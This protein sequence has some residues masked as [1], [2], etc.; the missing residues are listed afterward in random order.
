MNSYRLAVA[1]PVA[2]SMLFLAIMVFGIYAFLRLPVDL[3]PNIDVP[4]LSVITVYPGAGALEVEQNVTD[5]LEGVLGTVPNLKKMTSN[6]LDD[7]SVV[8]LEFDW[9]VDMSEAAND[10]RDRLGRASRLLPDG[11][12]DPF[13]QK[14][15]AG[16]IPVIIY[17]ATATESYANLE[18]I[19]NDNLVGPLNRIAGVGD[20]TITGA[21]ARQIH[22]TLD[23]ARLEAYNLDIQRVSQ[24]LQAENLSTPAGRIDLGDA[25]YNLRVN[26]EFRDLDDIAN[27]IVAN[28]QGRTVRLHQVGTVR[29]GF[30]DDV[31]VS[32]VNGRQGLTFAVM[33][34]SDANTVEVARAV[35]ARMPALLPSLPPDVEVEIIIDTSDFIVGSIENLSS[36]LFYA[37]LFVVLV[38]LVFLRQWRATIVV[39][40]TIPVSL[41]VAFIYLSLTGSTLNII[42]LSSLSIALGMVVDDAIVVLENIMRHIER[43]SRPREAAIYGTGE[44]AVA[45]IATTL[46]VVAVFL[47]LTFL[48]GPMGFWFGELGFIVVVT[49]VT[50]TIAALSLT[51]MMASL[52]LKRRG[53]GKTPMLVTRATSGAI[54]GALKGLERFYGGVLSRALRFR[55]T[56]IFLAIAIFAGSVALVP[57]I[58]TEY[59]PIADN[60]Q[61]VITGEF[62]TSRSLDYSARTVERIE[63]RL[64]EAIP[65]IVMLNSTAGRTGGMMGVSGGSN[66]F[67]IRLEIID[68]AERDRTVFDIADDVRALLDA[69]PEVVTSS[70]TAG[71]GGG[72]GATKPVAIQILGYDLTETTVIANALVAHMET[73]EGIRDVSLSRGANRPEFEVV[74]DRTR[75]SDF[76]LTS[77]QVASTVRG[78]IAG[79]TATRYRREGQEYDVVL[80]LD[81]ERRNTLDDLENLTILS[82]MGHRVPITEL[83]ELREFQVPPN[84]ERLDRERVLTVS[85]GLHERALN[86]ATDDIRKWV[87][88]QDFPPQVEIVFAGDIQDQQEAFRD[89]FLVLL[90]S[91]ILVY[92]VMAAQFESLK[93]PFVIMF[94]IPFAFTGVLLALLFTNT[95]LSVIGFVGGIILV[96][97]VVKN[98]IVL[99]DFIKLLRGRGQTVVAS[100]VDGSI[101]R[102][103]PVLMTTLTTILAMM[104]LALGIGEGAEIWQPMA[105][106]VVG[107]LAFST[108]V[109]LIIVPVIYGQ[110]E[111]KAIKAEEAPR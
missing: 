65:N 28:Y 3:F 11:I 102:L 10:V 42:S 20:V 12:D 74:F 104:P 105:I 36:V 59:M 7:L 80:R 67:N 72:G 5:N 88:A 35:R 94:S 44:V 23:P 45:V 83:G 6:S 62:E 93:E 109:T 99:I 46:T 92:I 68:R 110:F 33:K 41:I 50:S 18:Q 14:F 76:G 75:L 51:P 87:D 91:I 71:S 39:A 48:T 106:S 78:Y 108:V 95:P 84:I 56:T 89:L 34:Q 86:L 52:V 32:R 17:S 27:I 60:A 1:R 4:T 77:A 103:R 43:G 101:S 107:G 40:S 57:R 111:R 70:V 24:A 97:I 63:A 79:Q 25:S 58:G 21:P 61:L 90:L 38:V 37:V 16:A 64:K 66:Q 13:I 19:I 100:I 69:M 55:K 82:P 31:S 22:V 49:V 29:E 98:A 73:V 9:S 47:P 96:G 30:A 85:A 53:T 81:E 2:T 15:D 26:A 8:T 54:E